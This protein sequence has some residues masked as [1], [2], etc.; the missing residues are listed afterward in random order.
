MTIIKSVRLFT[1]LVVNNTRFYLHPDK[2]IIQAL[3]ASVPG[4]RDQY[5]QGGQDMGTSKQRI[6]TGVR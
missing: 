6:E 3:Q 2:H 5:K 4:L 1:V